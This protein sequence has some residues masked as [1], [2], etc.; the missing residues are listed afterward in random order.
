MHPNED[1]GEQALPAHM[2]DLP[3]YPRRG[4]PIPYVNA[5]TGDGQPDF[6]VLDS[7][8][9]RTVAAQRL[10]GVCGMPLDYW[11]AFVGGPRAAAERRYL[12][13]PMHPDCARASMWLC[14]WIARQEMRRLPTLRSEAGVPAGFGEDKPEEFLLY[15]TRGFRYDVTREGVIFRPNPAKGLIRYRYAGGRLGF[16]SAREN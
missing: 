2:E 3:V 13:P 11:V 1:L 5:S 9:V 16:G 4:I 10:C 14:P 15:L 12:D 6:A 7:E 8:K